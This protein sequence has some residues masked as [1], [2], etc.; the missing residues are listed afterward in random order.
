MKPRALI[1]FALLAPVQMAMAQQPAATGT[2]AATGTAPVSSPIWTPSTDITNAGV[3]FPVTYT[4]EVLGNPTGGHR[5]GAIYD[6]VLQAGITIDLGKLANWQ[7]AT[8]KVDGLYPHG[9]S[10]TRNDVRDFNGVSNI[11]TVHNPRLYEAWLEQSLDGGIFSIRAGQIPIDT[12]FFISTN[13][14]LFLNSAFGVIPSVSQNVNVAVYPV[15]APGVRLKAVPDSS[16]T[17]QAGVFDGIV[18]D[19]NSTNR[20]GL[21]FNLNSRDGAFAIAEVQYTLNPPPAAP[22]DGKQPT[23]QPLSG[24]YKLGA[25]YDSAN[26][27]DQASGQTL[28]GDY[29]FYFITDQQLWNA[30][31]APSQGLRGFLRISGVPPDR[32]QVQFYCDGGLDYQGLIPGRTQDLLGLGVSYTNL[33]NDLRDAKGNPYPNHYETIVELTYQAAVTSWLNIQPDAQYILNPGGLGTQ[34][35]A[36]VLGLRFTMTF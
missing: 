30:P 33:S 16:W 4:G 27:T 2:S 10:L 25:F 9:S 18:G 23:S 6:G 34:R 19:L 15:A 1:L 13:G 28:D 35:N 24:T 36:L 29:G 8:F 32:N 3:T 7:G 22:P 26:F 31:G 20:N 14:A 17:L 5:Q 21:R 11:D 12:E